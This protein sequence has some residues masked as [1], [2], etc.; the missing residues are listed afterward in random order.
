MTQTTGGADYHPWTTAIY[1][2]D[3]AR[4]RGDRK[5]G[6]EHLLLGLLREPAVAGA[7]GLDIEIARARLEALDRDALAAVGIGG[8]LDAPP[9][10]VREAVLP[11]RPTLASVLRDRMPMTPGAKT[12]LRDASKDMRRG[13]RITASQV[14]LAFLN[15]AAPDPA[16]ELIDA[17]GVDR[18]AARARLAAG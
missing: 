7:L 4:R 3:E 8:A 11:P 18:G 1:A 9:I 12:A 15:L 17:L 10:P 6:T 5:I 14:M 13:R 2:R 16:A